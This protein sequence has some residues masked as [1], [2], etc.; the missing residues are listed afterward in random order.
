MY[1]I[2]NIENSL[3]EYVLKEF[4]RYRV[5]LFFKRIADSLGAI[6]REVLALVLLVK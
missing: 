5:R 3:E 2:V 1:V 4:M 6:K